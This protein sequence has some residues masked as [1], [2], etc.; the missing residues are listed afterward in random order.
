[1]STRRIKAL[2]LP[3]GV[4]TGRPAKGHELVSLRSLGI[5]PLPAGGAQGTNTAGDVLTQTVDGRDLN[6]VWR[7]FQAALRAYNTTRNRLVSLLTFPVTAPVE[8]VPIIATGDFEEASE[9]G[10]PK[11]I[12]GGGFESFGYDFKWYDLAV[13]FTW[14]FLAEA[15]AA[16]VDSL[17]EMALE[18]DNR[19]VFTKVLRAIFNNTDR[20][21]VIRQQALNVYPLYNADG[22]VPPNYKNYTFD[23]THNHYLVSGAATVDSGDLDEMATQIRHHGHGTNEAGGRLLL[24]VNEAQLATI[25]TFSRTGGDSYDFIPS[26]GQPPF[27]LPAQ[28]AGI[29]GQAPPNTFAGFDVVG[30]YGPWLVIEENYVPEDYLLG[31]ATGGDVSAQN[32]VGIREHANTGLRGLQLVKGPT[33]DYPLI[34][35]FYRRGFGT[36][37][38]QRGAGVVMQVKASGTY[39][40]PA[41]YA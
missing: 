36:G 20:T 8:D 28:T 32:L 2:V 19:L 15:G 31:V 10:E 12:R 14:Q 1:M 21:T 22:I 24:F 18:A 23:G 7:E 3:G 4:A 26:S 16:Q 39:D 25:R 33:P 17:N 34:D 38:R 41:A 37:I 9:F 29:E 6:E 35:S 27:L 11:G 13:R 40:I 30:S 5:Y